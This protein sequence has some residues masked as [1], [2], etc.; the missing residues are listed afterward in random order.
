MKSST[1]NFNII[2]FILG[3]FSIFVSILARK[4]NI[5]ISRAFSILA[6]FLFLGPNFLPGKMFG[7]WNAARGLKAKDVTNIILRP[8]QPGFE[9]NLI[10]S[11]TSV[12]NK[13]QIINIVNLLSNTEMFSPSHPMR[14]WETEMILVTKDSDS[15]KLEIDRTENNGTIIYATNNTYKKDE[16]GTYLERIVNFKRPVRAKNIGAEK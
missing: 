12:S 15:L 5:K 13:D 6:I 10:D 7:K 14:K 16:I 9:V 1:M 4:R 8:S 3:L 11:T 2:S